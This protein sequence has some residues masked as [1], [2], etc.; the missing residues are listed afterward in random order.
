MP[1]HQTLPLIDEIKRIARLL[2]KQ[3]PLQYA[4]ALDI[5]AKQLGYQNFRHAQ[6]AAKTH[7]S[8]TAPGAVTLPA[9]FTTTLSQYWVDR[10]LGVRGRETL[11]ILLSR[12]LEEISSLQKLSHARGLNQLMRFGASRF[13][14]EYVTSSQKKA[15]ETLYMAA[16]T[17]DFMDA[18]GLQPSS[19]YRR[20]LPSGQWSVPGEDHARSWYDP[21]TRRY[22]IADEPY[23]RDI[24]ADMP[25]R[26]EWLEK[27]GYVMQCPDWLGMYN[28]YVDVDNGSRLYL[29]T[30][31]TKGVDLDRVVSALNRLSPPIGNQPWV[32]VSEE[33]FPLAG[34]RLASF[35]VSGLRP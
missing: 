16:R 23:Q 4:L 30:H 9:H 28:P 33:Q 19:G 13:E 32:G 12:P 2:K 18:T 21:A 24:Q 7:P 8:I 17:L 6:N 27:F 20:A 22:L 14:M 15:Q 1:G 29:I 31:A 5:A 35:P 11:D 25:K 10:D 3:S 34:S 26:V